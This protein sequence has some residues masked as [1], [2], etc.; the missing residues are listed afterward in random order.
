MRCKFVLLTALALAASTVFSQTNLMKN[1]GFEEGIKHWGNWTNGAKCELIQND[2]KSGKNALRYSYNEPK[3]QAIIVNNL[4][5]IPDTIYTVSAFLKGEADVLEVKLFFWG[6]KDKYLGESAPFSGSSLKDWFHVEKTFTVPQKTERVAV[7]LLIKNGYVIADDFSVI[8]GKTERKAQNELFNTSFQ[9]SLRTDNMPEFWNTGGGLSYSTFQPG[10]AEG[11]F[12]RRATDVKSPIPGTGVL[13]YNQVGGMGLLPIPLAGNEWYTFSLYAKAEKPDSK[14]TLSLNGMQPAQ[15]EFKVGTE[16]TRIAFSAFLG[17]ADS[18]HSGRI[19][20]HRNAFYIAAPM[21]EAGKTATEWRPNPKDATLPNLWAGQ[22]NVKTTQLPRV[23]CP[24]VNSWDKAEFLDVFYENQFGKSVKGKFRTW[25]YTKDGTFYVAIESDTGK[26]QSDIQK[27]NNPQQPGNELAE[28]FLSPNASGAPYWHFMGGRNGSQFAEKGIGGVEVKGDWKYSTKETTKGWRAEFEIPLSLIGLPGQE[29]WRMS[30][31]ATEFVDAKPIYYSASGKDGYHKPTGFMYVKGL[32]VGGK[33]VEPPVRV[34]VEYDLYMNEKSATAIVADIGFPANLTVTSQNGK[35]VFKKQLQENKFEI[36]LRNLPEGYYEVEVS[37][38]DRNGKSYFRKLPYKKHT[39]RVDRF[40][41]QIQVNEKPFFPMVFSWHG[42]NLPSRIPTQWHIEELRKH[43]FNTILLMPELYV[44]WIKSNSPEIRKNVAKA[45]A[46]AGFKIIIWGDGPKNF[47]GIQSMVDVRKSQIAELA[48]YD[49]AII[50]WYFVDEI[51][52]NWEKQFNLKEPDFAKGYRQL[53]DYSPYN[54]HFINWN[55]T[56]INEGQK[57]Y[58]SE[59]STDIYSLDCYPYCWNI[60]FGALETHERAA[61][62]AGNRSRL[63]FLPGIIWLQTYSYHEGLREPHQKEYRNNV[64][65]S[66]INNQVGF[67]NFIGRPESNDLWDGMG[68]AYGE[69]LKWLNMTAGKGAEQVNSGKR[70]SIVYSLWKA[71]DNSYWFVCANT[72]YSN[73]RAELDFNST[74][75]R[76]F[77]GKIHLEGGSGKLKLDGKALSVEL[78]IAE[79]AMW[80]IAGN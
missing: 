30:L 40:K 22:K 27:N 33:I 6:E 78:G 39:A 52:P 66:L 7:G 53:K 20:F 75:A 1:P 42:L 29:T 31:C 61:E 77:A 62:I 51:G 48:A 55:W 74:L 4:N 43:N 60:N 25:F 65:V 68:K 24:T 26:K 64:Y 32:P 10:H 67:M 69:A 12:F 37:S 11:K 80:R 5:L 70:G 23:N 38:K 9:Y 63:D 17:K 79:S 58:A 41:Q 57:W 46:D 28:L 34:A 44:D 56:G 59:D 16:W 19:N 14:I 36:P 3:K 72:S 76:P 45:F 8:E 49:D 13:Y 50:G 71:A 73:E 35:I 15:Q 18:V 2:V 54:L 21:L 47:N